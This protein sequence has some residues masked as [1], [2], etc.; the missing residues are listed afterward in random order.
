[1]EESLIHNGKKFISSKQAAS[2]TGYATDYIGQLCRAKKVD[3]VLIGRTW[4]VDENSIL[5][6][7]ENFQIHSSRYLSKIR[8]KELKKEINK[9]E[10]IEKRKKP[11]P[12]SPEYRRSLLAKERQETMPSP[13]YYTERSKIL[14]PKITK[15][16][17]TLPVGEPTKSVGFEKRNISK[18]KTPILSPFQSKLISASVAGVILFF[19]VL[20]SG[21]GM[22]E[23]KGLKNFKDSKTLSTLNSPRTEIPLLGYQSAVSFLSDSANYLVSGMTGL[24]SKGTT[25]ASNK[26][27]SWIR[28]KI[29]VNNSPQPSLA[30]REGERTI[31][32]TYIVSGSARNYIDQ[33]ISELKN[34]FTVSI[35]QKV[36]RTFLAIQNDTMADLIGGTSSSGSSSGI[37][38]TSLSASSPISYNSGTGAFS[39]DF[40]TTNNWSGQNVFQNASTTIVGNLTIGGNATTT[41]ATT[42]TFAITGIT[43]S[44]LKTDANGSIIGATAGADY[45]TLA[46][47]FGKAWE[48]NSQGFLAPT[49]TLSVFLGQATSTLFSANQAWFGSNGTTT[50]SS[51]GWVG[52]GSSS[53]VSP[54]HV[55]TG[56]GSLS[57]SNS[58]AGD[59]IFVQDNDTTGSTANL[60]FLAGNNASSVI[61]FGDTDDGD[62][63]NITYSHSGNYLSMV[64]NNTER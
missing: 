43:S 57:S 33:K 12:H 58:R 11:L 17:P 51:G 64:T 48:I 44:L 30:L 14:F 47:L 3:S 34:Y 26:I 61:F 39:F 62:I 46:N 9:R 2:R 16:A 56:N 21:T 53:P 19:V 18:L 63:G 55:N 7:K 32:Q 38:L 45:L 36:D 10:G 54:L 49:T 41:N 52:I 8:A 20:L 23:I 13:R 15:Y 25:Y 40:S 59:Q 35:S 4:Y 37:S 42:T 27:V 24:W 1:M 5:K 29:L 6:H 28:S 50:I 31:A 22:E 60:A